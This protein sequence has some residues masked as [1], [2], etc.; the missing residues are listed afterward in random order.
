[1]SKMTGR[2]ICNKALDL[3]GGGGRELTINKKGEEHENLCSKK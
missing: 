2:E 3:I 1:M